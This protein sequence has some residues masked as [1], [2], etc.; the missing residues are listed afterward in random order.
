MEREDVKQIYTRLELEETFQALQNEVLESLYHTHPDAILRGNPT[1]L[2]YQ[3]WPF[4]VG[5]SLERCRPR[6]VIACDFPDNESARVDQPHRAFRHRHV[7]S[8]KA[9]ND[10][11]TDLKERILA[12]WYPIRV[13]LTTGRVRVYP[14]EQNEFLA[15][16]TWPVYYSIHAVLPE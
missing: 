2:K 6:Q 4:L 3:R 15:G 5:P 1:Q 10:S 12:Q 14:P 13:L 11:I 9:W 16:G 7:I 8:D